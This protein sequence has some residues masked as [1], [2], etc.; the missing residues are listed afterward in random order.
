MSDEKTEKYFISL[1]GVP[2][3]PIA[4]DEANRLIDPSIRFWCSRRIENDA[5]PGPN[6]EP[7][8]FF[9]DQDFWC[10]PYARHQASG[11]VSPYQYRSCSYC[12]SAHPDD[13][14]LHIE[15]GKEIGPTDK[16]YK[17][18]LDPN[19][20]KFY[21]QHLNTEQKRKFVDLLNANK[22]NIGFPGY[23]YV[24]PYFLVAVT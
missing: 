6:G 9:P 23:F 22:L 14:F 11:N 17:I 4:V 1:A 20:N 5:M 10:E 3:D 24:K 2:A 16:T 7:P 21:F 19:P 15:A 8:A 13:L 12:G 18:Y